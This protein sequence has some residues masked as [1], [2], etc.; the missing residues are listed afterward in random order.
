MMTLP[1]FDIGTLPAVAAELG[2]LGYGYCSSQLS[3]HKCHTIITPAFSFPSPFIKAVGIY[4]YLYHHQGFI[5]YHWMCRPQLQF[6]NKL[7]DV[8]Q[9]EDE[10]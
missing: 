8:R 5:P 1:S 2:G 3:M 10:M 4:L 6:K 7:R 9:H